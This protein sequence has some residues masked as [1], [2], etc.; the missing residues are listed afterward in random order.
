MAAHSCPRS[1]VSSYSG[2][3]SPPPRTIPSENHPYRAVAASKAG[4]QVRDAICPT[5]GSERICLAFTVFIAGRVRVQGR[6]RCWARKERK[7]GT[8]QRKVNFCWIPPPVTA[9][10]LLWGCREAATA[11]VLPFCLCDLAG[12]QIR[13]ALPCPPV[14]FFLVAP[15]PYGS[16]KA[17]DWIRVQLQ[18]HWIL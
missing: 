9:L 5:H 7:Y 10:W 2:C 18:Q 13:P 8:H 4:R 1:W 17:R 11:Y 15:A 6:A 3:L 12:W 16:S 14:F